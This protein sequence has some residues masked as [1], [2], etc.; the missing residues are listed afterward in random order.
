M[1][2]DDCCSK[3]QL[4]S[5]REYGFIALMLKKKTKTKPKQKNNIKASSIK[6]VNMFLFYCSTPEFKNTLKECLL[7]VFHFQKH[8]M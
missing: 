3:T 1:V 6:Y 2:I 4:M 8:F 5:T 7:F